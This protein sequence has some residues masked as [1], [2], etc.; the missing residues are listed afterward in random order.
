MLNFAF[1]IIIFE[2]LLQY[3]DRKLVCIGR[4]KANIFSVI[5]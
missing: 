4:Q 3:F 5:F 1:Y 2:G